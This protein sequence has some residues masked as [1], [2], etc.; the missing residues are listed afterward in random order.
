MRVKPTLDHIQMRTGQRLPGAQS[1]YVD[2]E[3]FFQQGNPAAGGAKINTVQ[4]QRTQCH[5]AIFI[6]YQF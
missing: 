3:S 6:S 5:I 2:P 4:G 1:G